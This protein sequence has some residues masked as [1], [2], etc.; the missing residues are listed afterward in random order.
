MTIINYQNKRFL[1]VDPIKPSRDSLKQLA[2]DLN[3]SRIDTSFYPNDVIHMC[4]NI[5]YDVIFLGYDLGLEQKNGQQ[6]LEELRVNKIISRQCVVIIVTAENSQ[7]MVLAALEHKPDDYLTKP[8]NFKQLT[9]RLE[10]CFH[11]KHNMNKIYKA[12]DDKRHS[13][14]IELCQ[15]TIKQ[16][17]PYRLE[18]LGIQS[19]Q[20]FDLGEF[21]KAKK[22]YLSHQDTPNCEWA[23]MGLGKIALLEHEYQL[24]S[25]IFEKLITNSPHYLSA[26]DWLA[27]AFKHVGEI[28]KSEATLEQALSLSPRSVVRLQDYATYCLQNKNYEKAT[29]ALLK[30]HELAYNS[31]HHRPENAL[32]LAQSLSEYSDGI[33][34]SEAKR[35]NNKAFKAL[36]LMT[37][38]F[39]QIGLKIQS[40]LLSALLFKNTKELTLSKNMMEQAKKSLVKQQE[41]IPPN[42]L[43]AICKSLF[44][45][46]E[47]QIA[48]KLINLVVERYSDDIIIMTEIDKLIDDSVDNEEKS[49]AEQALNSALSSY[50]NK[51]PS[52]AITK[53][54]KAQTCFPNHFGLKLTLLQ[55]LLNN[56]EEEP[57]QEKQRQA[58]NEHISSFNNISEGHCLYSRFRKLKE[59]YTELAG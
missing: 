55:I 13:T 28:K 9:L 44:K 47:T 11:K 42:N 43:I 29:Q 59:K 49:K 45:L 39:N 3:A 22:I 21:S 4:E 18:C 25:E 2:Q 7:A 16:G 31:I 23:C 36:A 8:Y 38:E 33:P 54:K 14:V 5:D 24:A 30:A 57:N 41:T 17:T 20:Y 52:L 34:V 53:L 19:R 35:L 10:R 51:N 32:I 46:N 40:N 26:Y 50:K 27:Q 1:I 37:K 58:V 56:Y 15:E 48:H 6:L 12:L